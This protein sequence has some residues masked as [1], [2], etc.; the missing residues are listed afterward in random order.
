LCRGNADLSLA[1]NRQWLEQ[2][3]ADHAEDGCRPA[4]AEGQRQDGESGVYRPTDEPAH[5]V[6]GVHDPAF[7]HRSSRSHPIGAWLET[8][9]PAKPDA[10][11]ERRDRTDPL[12]PHPAACRPYAVRRGA[13][14]E[15]ILE[16]DQH[17]IALGNREERAHQGTNR[18]GWARGVHST[19]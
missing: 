3:R 13:T 4:G 2:Q 7:E 11:D 16:I 6:P 14:L 5:R 19:L 15:L 18:A 8:G 1:G 10:R 17:F 9:H 12:P